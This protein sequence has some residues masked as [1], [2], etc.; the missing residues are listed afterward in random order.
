MSVG[1]YSYGNPTIKWS[2]PDAKY[3]CGKF[4]SI[5]V[6]VTIYLGNG[7]GHDCSFV[8]TYPFGYIHQGVFPDVSNCSRDTKGS[9]TIGNDVWIGENVIIMSGVTIGDGAVIANNSHV[10]RNVEPYTIVGGNPAAQI[11]YRFSKEQIAK[12]L[13]IKWWDWDDTKIN[14]HMGLICSNRID[15]FILECCVEE[16]TPTRRFQWRN[17]FQIFMGRNR[18]VPA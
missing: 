7:H 10:V 4:C 11:K 3:S 16:L 15:E 9:V 13:E 8:S 1:K 6:D 5:A 14:R 18:I 17:M 12:L 2:N